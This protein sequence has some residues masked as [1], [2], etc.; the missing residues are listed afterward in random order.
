MRRQCGRGGR[1]RDRKSV[2]LGEVARLGAT[3]AECLFESTSRLLG[4]VL[5]ERPWRRARL[6]DALDGCVLERAEARG[7]GERSV[8]VGGAEPGAK[9]E[10]AAR[11][12]APNAWRAGAQQT[13]E[14][15]SALAH[16]LECAGEAI[17]IDRTLSARRWMETGRIELEPRASRRELVARDAGEVGGVDEQLALRDAHGED[18]GDVVVGDGVTVALPVDEAVDAA[19]AIGN[20]RGVVG[21]AREGQELVL[22]VGEALEA[23]APLATARALIDDRV[24]PLGELAADIVEVVERAGVEERA[25][26]LPEAPL[27]ARLGV[28][29]AADGSWTEL[30]VSR[31]GEEPRVVDRLRAL[32]SE[33]DG[34]LAV[35]SASLRGATEALEG[36][37]V[38]VHQRVQVIREEDVE[39][40][41]G[42]VDKDI[43][44]GLD[45]E[46][47]AAR[48]LD[49]EGRPV[50]LGHLAGAVLRRRAAR[51]RLLRRPNGANVFLDRGVAAGESFTPQDLED[52]LRGDV[53]VALE[54][55]GNSALEAVDLLRARC[56]RCARRKRRVRRLALLRVCGEHRSDRVSADVERAR[57]RAPRHAVA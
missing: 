38:T 46:S 2:V 30:V 5:V 7:V 47:C 13:E 8:D 4:D 37:G 22:L 28:G 17:E 35:V 6:D 25:N 20:A 49:R 12:V 26:H 41:S 9:E 51:L 21:V 45:V 54:E 57:D 42:A 18:V 19:E 27:D 43:G 36:V 29:Q 31:E 52:T 3:L 14:G 33:D 44:E 53:G 48:E 56:A 55:L 40:L 24:E 15:G 10:N 11:L 39:V 50:A 23:G 34:L 16:A 1:S 32:P